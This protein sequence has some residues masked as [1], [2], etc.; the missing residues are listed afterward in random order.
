MPAEDQSTIFTRFFRASNATTAN[1]PGTGL[2]LVIVRMIVENHG[3]RVDLESEVDRG[4]TVSVSLPLRAETVAEALAEDGVD[5]PEQP[6][7]SS[8]VAFTP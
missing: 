6:A 5:P 1:I 7:V 4:A 8:G 2:G 3:G